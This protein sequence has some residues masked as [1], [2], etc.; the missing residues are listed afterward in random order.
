MMTNGV[1][2]GNQG[3]QGV[4]ITA[5]HELSELILVPNLEPMAAQTAG[6]NELHIPVLLAIGDERIF[7]YVRG[8]DGKGIRLE[9][10]SPIRAGVSVSFGFSLPGTSDLVSVSAHVVW[11]DQSGRLAIGYL[12][13]SDISTRMREWFTTDRKQ[14]ND[15]FLS[16]MSFRRTA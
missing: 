7:A 11:I 15:N 3:H 2:S 1:S 14:I 13:P 10:K 8:V 6:P 5:T 9:L 4:V 16:T 12:E